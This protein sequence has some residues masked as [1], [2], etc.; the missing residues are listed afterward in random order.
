VPM[1]AAA[2]TGFVLCSASAESP[3]QAQSRTFTSSATAQSW[4][5]PKSGDHGSTRKGRPRVPIGGSTRGTTVVWGDYGLRMTDHHRRLS[6]LQLKNAEDTIR[7]RLRG[8]KYRLY[9]RISANIP[10]YTKGNETRMGT[11][12]GSMDFWAAR[13][14][15]SRV[16]FELKGE[17]HE[18]IVKDAF[19]VAS[20]KMPGKYETIKKGDVP[21]M[22]TTKLTPENVEKLMARK[23][24]SQFPLSKL[25]SANTPAPSPSD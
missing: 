1:P 11:G 17:I 4:L 13:V 19:R 21:V 25:A 16:I 22:G 9:T 24:Q 8:M 10:V 15:V 23:H 18:Q 14:P 3:R 6:A 7:Q 5:L 2:R 12:K 20:A